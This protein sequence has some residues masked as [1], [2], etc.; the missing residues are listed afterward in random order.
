MRIHNKI[1]KSRSYI[2]R[3]DW[4]VSRVSLKIK[5]STNIKYQVGNYVYMSYEQDKKKSKS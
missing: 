1:Q 3:Q 2:L 5:K 4:R